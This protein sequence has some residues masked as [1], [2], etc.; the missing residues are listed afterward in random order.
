[1][2]R[3][4]NFGDNSNTFMSKTLLGVTIVL[5]GAANTAVGYLDD[6]LCWSRVAMAFS[7]DNLSC[8]G[9]FEDGEIDAHDERCKRIE[10]DRWKY[11]ISVIIRY[12][13]SN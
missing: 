6:D 5:V 8:L 12:S 7:F 2:D 9:T 11:Q 3:G 4:A 1:M 10:L 13:T